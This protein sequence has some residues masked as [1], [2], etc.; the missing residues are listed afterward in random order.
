MGWGEI[1]SAANETWS[2]SRINVDSSGRINQRGK[3]IH[4]NEEERSFQPF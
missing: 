2:N 4:R 3:I 1:K